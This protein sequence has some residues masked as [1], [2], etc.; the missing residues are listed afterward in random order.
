MAL[1]VGNVGSTVV[2]VD[3]DKVNGAARASGH[4]V[5][6][7]RQTHWGAA[8]G[9]GGS[10]ELDLT[11]IGLDVLHVSGSGVRGGQVRL[12]GHVG[13]IEGEN[14]SGA[15]SNCGDDVG[16]PDGSMDSAGTPQHRSVVE[17]GGAQAGNGA[18]PVVG[19]SD[20]GV[21]LEG[22]RV[23]DIAVSDS[24]LPSSSCSGS[25]SGRSTG[26]WHGNR[27]RG[28]GSRSDNDDGGS[29]GRGGCNDD[30]GGRS[31]SGCDNDGGSG[32]RGRCH[33]GGGSRGRRSDD[34]ISG[35]LRSA[36]PMPSVAAPI[37]VGDRSSEGDRSQERAD[38]HL[39]EGRH[40]SSKCSEEA[41]MRYVCDFA[42]KM[43]SSG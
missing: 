30:G 23:Q 26:D 9:D 13:L 4:E 42:K 19:P 22:D 3:D 20:G 17:A 29:R 11:G 16:L 27:S 39:E 41:E 40:D 1:E 31:R 2:P 38:G 36:G 8:V 37:D 24:A 33:D 14:V 5:S 28:C 32:S 25:D 21:A 15:S 10:T 35:S 12:G 43:L 34:S 7:P 18:V 6:E